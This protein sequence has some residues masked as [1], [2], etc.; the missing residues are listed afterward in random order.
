M[1]YPF[2][3]SDVISRALCGYN[4]DATAE[5][6][7]IGSSC[8]ATQLFNAAAFPLVLVELNFCADAIICSRAWNLDNAATLLK[9]HN[10]HCFSFL[11]QPDAIS[12]T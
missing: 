9:H 8:I 6:L 3:V 4:V 7:K 2:F 5:P 11:S 1:V 10:K 12:I